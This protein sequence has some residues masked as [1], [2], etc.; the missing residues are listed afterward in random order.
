MTPQWNNATSYSQRDTDRAPRT[1]N[2][3]VCGL[4]ICVTRR[5]GLEGWYLICE[6]WHS[7]RLLKSADIDDA[8]AEAMEL[9]GRRARELAKAFGEL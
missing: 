8:K 1:W 3:D 6:P 9:I 5:H 2:M 4:R 7:L